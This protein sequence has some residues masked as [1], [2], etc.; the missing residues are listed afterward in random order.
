MLISSEVNSSE[1]RLRVAIIPSVPG[2]GA[3]LTFFVVV[4][5]TFCL[6]IFKHSFPRPHAIAELN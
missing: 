4:L 2:L 1:E 3:Y 5:S 6:L